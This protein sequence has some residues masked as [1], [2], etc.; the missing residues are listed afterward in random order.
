[1]KAKREERDGGVESHELSSP[2]YLNI[3]HKY[4]RAAAVSVSK[5]QLAAV[6]IS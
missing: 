1:M 4:R 3:Q 6:S 2:L 5:Q